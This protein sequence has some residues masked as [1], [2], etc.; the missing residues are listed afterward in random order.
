MS[1]QKSFKGRYNEIKCLPSLFAYN[2][3]ISSES[4]FH[5][6]TGHEGPKGE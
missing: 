3:T 6:K 5:S 2:I 1:I 4:E